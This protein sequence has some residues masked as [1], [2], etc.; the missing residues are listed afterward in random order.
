[1]TTLSYRL[2]ILLAATSLLGTAH[3]QSTATDPLFTAAPE[4]LQPQQ[5]RSLQQRLSDWPQLAYYRE[6]NARLPAPRKGEARVVFYGDSITE[7]WGRTG[8]E[9]F[10]PGK[11]YLNRGIS[12]QTTAQMLLRFRQDVIA[13]DPAVVVILA[14]TNDIA[15]NTGPASQAMIEDNLHSM[16]ELA[17]AHGIKVALSSVLPVSAYPWRPGLQPAASVRAL[18]AALK[19]YAEQQRLVYL[20]YHAALGNADG[21]LDKALAED[22]VHPTPAGYAKMAPLAEAAVAAALA[23]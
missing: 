1:M 15:G 20:D 16:V 7:G 11:G 4:S 22:G 6:Q 9:S 21:G 10:F 17:Q 18:N 8:S 3:A 19:G 13:L 5:V 12:G 2:S 23:H 14:G